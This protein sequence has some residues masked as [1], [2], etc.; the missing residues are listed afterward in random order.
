MLADLHGLLDEHVEILGNVWCQTVGL[1]DAD[2][3]LTGD[4]ADLGDAVGIT[5]NDTNL[6]GSESLLGQFADVVLDV[7]RGDLEP[8]GR[9]A[10]VWAGTLGDT[11]AWCVHATHDGNVVLVVVVVLKRRS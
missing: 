10:F 7:L 4:A 5:E 11:L 3:L 2:N 8:A 9:G 1:E 6:R